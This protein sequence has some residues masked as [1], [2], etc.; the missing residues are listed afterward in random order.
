MTMEDLHFKLNSLA[1][2]G[3]TDSYFIVKTK[4][5]I[6][7]PGHNLRIQKRSRHLNNENSVQL[8][9]FD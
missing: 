8:S 5:G 2:S 3:M 1:L 9:L 4:Q 6:K 7:N